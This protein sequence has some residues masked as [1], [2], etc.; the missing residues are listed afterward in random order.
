MRGLFA[1]PSL[2]MAARPRLFPVP[3]SLFPIPCF[4]LPV[5]YPLFPNHC[6]M[7][8]IPYSAAASL[9]HA[10]LP[11]LSQSYRLK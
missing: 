5:P 2:A 10:D 11:G 9:R 6:S 7:F 3:Y 1:E 8:P 4:S